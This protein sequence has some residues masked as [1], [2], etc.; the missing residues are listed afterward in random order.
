VSTK[1]FAN[2]EI[3]GYTVILI[4]NQG[5]NKGET[6]KYQA[7]KMAKEINLDLV[8]VGKN[9]KGLA[10]CKFADVGKLRYQ[11]SKNKTYAKPI[12]TKE[13]MFHLRTGSNDIQIKKNKIRAMLAKK[14]NVKFGI[15][16]KGRERE[17]IQNAKLILENN[18]KDLQDVAVWDAM[19][20]LNDSVYYM[21]K[22]IKD[23]E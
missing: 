6:V 13:M 4:D 20:L 5:V 22:P 2:E 3:Y 10:I 8:Q 7:I 12:E 21:L 17:F 23:K 15:Q 9:E 16:L 11:A 19:N 18:V 1:I 14:C